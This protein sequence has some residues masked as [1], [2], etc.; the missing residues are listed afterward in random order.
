MSGETQGILFAP[1]HVH[2]GEAAQL[3]TKLLSSLLAA[4]ATCIL[5]QS[6][7]GDT[8]LKKKLQR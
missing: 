4:L 3:I 8:I 6:Y 5:L 7:N 2:V 1:I